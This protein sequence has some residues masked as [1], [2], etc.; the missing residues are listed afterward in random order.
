MNFISLIQIFLFLFFNGIP[1]GYTASSS[2]VLTA[3]TKYKN[4]K[5][6]K[7]VTHGKHKSVFGNYFDKH[8]HGCKFTQE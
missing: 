1:Y 6:G 2:S 7:T 3:S 8:N 5:F 4:P